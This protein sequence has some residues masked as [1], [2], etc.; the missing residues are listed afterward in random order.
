M[1]QD[2]FENISYYNYT[3]ISADRPLRGVRQ[4]VAYT[5]IGFNII[6]FLVN[7]WVLFV[8]GPLLFTSSVKVPKSILF[9]II[10]LCIS[11]LIIM[12]GMLLLI[13]ELVLGTWKLSAFA[14][15][16]YLIFDGINKF[17][18][19]MIVFLI[20][21]TCYSTVCLKGQEKRRAASLKFAVLKVIGA[22]AIVMLLLWPVFAYSDIHKLYVNANET[23]R[24]VTVISKCSFAPPQKIELFFSIWACIAS[25]AIP[26]IGIIYWYMSVPFFLR[27]RAETTMLGK[28]GS[29]DLAI[30]KVITTVLVLTL[31]YVLCWSPYWISLFTL[32]FLENI[33]RAVVVFSYF[34]HLLPY[35]SCS[36]YPLIFTLMN[37]AI[38][39]AHTQMLKSHRRRIQSFTED[40]SRHLRENV[41]YRI[42]GYVDRTF[43]N[44]RKISSISVRADG[45]SHCSI[46][47]T[48][49]THINSPSPNLHTPPSN[50]QTPSPSF[51]IF[52]FN[53]LEKS[54]TETLTRELTNGDIQSCIT[55]DETEILL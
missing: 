30:R 25:Y 1:Q 17:A 7:G 40:A 42:L 28:N 9:Y 52:S 27:K 55:D 31:V 20:S 38:K 47:P 51:C 10:T 4:Y 49:S 34:I 45:A 24:E 54:K 48:S 6:G 12:I 21:R 15:V 46:H 36:A 13:S 41:G 14:C 32:R 43:S 26:L 11:D 2:P 23:T 50:S 53:S 37:R 35:I 5:Y 3:E 16:S 19:P 44:G 39:V 22:L 18:A 8:V 29:N 33:P